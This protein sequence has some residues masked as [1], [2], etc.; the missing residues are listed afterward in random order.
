MAEASR[1]KGRK[2]IPICKIEKK[3][4]LDVSFSKRKKGVFKKASELSTLSGAELAIIIFSPANKVH[5][6]G[7]PNVETII[8]RFSSRNSIQNSSTIGQHIKAL[9]LANASE[10]NAHLHN[11]VSQLEMEKKRGEELDRTW[12]GRP[13]KFW[14]EDSLDE[15]DKEKL[16]ELYKLVEITEK[17]LEQN[18]ESLARSS[19]ISNAPFPFAYNNSDN[20]LY[21]GEGSSYGPVRYPFL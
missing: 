3:A 14:W 15:M 2:K 10:L 12:D 9:Q 18:F 6:F 19:M 20:G 7:N 5:S 1:S 21:H 13:H 16:M 11:M 8:N 4:S 17:N